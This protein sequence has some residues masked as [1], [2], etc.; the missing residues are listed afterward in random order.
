MIWFFVTLLTAHV[1]GAVLTA[2]L[3]TR[4]PRLAVAAATIPHVVSIALLASKAPQV[5]DG[6]RLTASVPWAPGLDLTLSFQLDGLALMMGLLVA[7]AGILVVLFA[8]GYTGRSG[9]M[10]PML[11]GLVAFAGAMQMLVVADDLLTLFLGWELTSIASFGLIGQ[12]HHVTAARDAARQALLVTGTGGLALLAGLVLIGQATDTW[13]LSALAD[14]GVPGGAAV[15]AGVLLVVIGAATKSAQFPFSTWL[16]GAMA[17]PTPVSAYLHSA[18]MVKAGVFLL[19]RMSPVLGDT[20]TWTPLVVSVGCVTLLT[21]GWRALQADDAKQLLAWSTVSQLGLLITAIGVGGEEVLLGVLAL[22][23]AHALAKAGLF[24]VVGA[25]DV[26]TGTRDVRRLTGVWRRFP[27]LGIGVVAC[28]ASLSGIPLLAGFV[29]KEAV[30][31]GLLHEGTLGTWMA[32]AVAAGSALTVAYTLRLIRAGLGPVDPQPSRRAVDPVRVRLLAWPGAALG[33]LSLAVGLAP[34]VQDGVVGTALASISEVSE[35]PHLYIWHGFTVALGLS[36]LAI[37]G[38]FLVIRLLGTGHAPRLWPTP[39]EGTFTDGVHLLGDLARRMSRITQSGSLPIY[40][41][42]MLAVLIVLPGVPLVAAAVIEGS[43]PGS[44][45]RPGDVLLALA[46]AAAA[47]VTART[48]RRFAAIMSL[49]AV[50]FGIALVFV[51]W[52]APDLA[53]TQMVVETLGLLLFVLALRDLPRRF[54][55]DPALLSPALRWIL[56]A[57]VGSLVTTFTLVASAARTATPPS[58]Q[59]AALAEPD[60]GGKNIVNVIL[61][62]IRALDTLGEITVLLVAAIGIAVMVTTGRDTG[63]SLPVEEVVDSDAP[64]D[65]TTTGVMEETR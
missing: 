65:P 32:V 26:I 43:V 29:A 6:E 23:V 19:L 13:T 60:G 27:S 15:E 49:G 46:I 35:T 37:G 58:A 52:G 62:D 44:V 17:A 1:I 51:R 50:G 12:T 7:V 40:L 38:G 11:G 3:G 2:V 42:T 33:V 25:A 24:M 64:A 4:L 53:L 31:E 63:P 55:P 47:V 45:V 56:A 61:T 48:E 30:L 59:L 18:T 57:G 36:T 34:G 20:Q 54:G 41:A 8:A 39:P 5:L 14:T 28:G 9:K 22:V 16:P 21:A 10:G